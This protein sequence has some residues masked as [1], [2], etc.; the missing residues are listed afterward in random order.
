MKSN[1]VV[2]T[3]LLLGLAAC[4]KPA[5][6]TEPTAKQPSV[7]PA[8]APAALERTASPAGARVFFIK[9]TDGETLRNP[10]KIEF[11]IEGMDVVK[12]G[13]AQPDSGHHH[14]LIDTGLP[15][16]GLPIPSD[17]NY[18]HFG[19]GSRSTE[20]TLPP[21]THTLSLLLGDHRHIPHEPPVAS[22]PITVTIE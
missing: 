11:G 16:L 20:I 18:I 12:A 19:D 3:F 15:P 9:P 2:A 17:A 10:V 6:E 1:L 5:N 13:N 8:A 7:A 22:L 14:L 21:G 4:G